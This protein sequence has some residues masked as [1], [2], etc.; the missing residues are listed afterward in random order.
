MHPVLLMLG[1]YFISAG[2]FAINQA[3]EW[4]RDKVMP[5]TFYRPLPQGK[6]Q[7]WQAYFLGFIFCLFGSF[8]LYVLSPLSAGLG[9]LTI[10]LY[11]GAYT[12]FWKRKMAFGAVPGAIPGAMPV[13]IGYAANSTNIFSL[14]C[15]YLF[16]IMFLWQMPHFWCLAIRFKD[17]YK[18]GGFPVLPVRVG[19]PRTLYFIGLYVFAYVAL[20]LASPL[21]VKTNFFYLLFVVPLGF[22]VLYEFIKYF[23]SEAQKG[24][25]PF[26]LWTNLSVLIFLGVPVFDKW[27]FYYIY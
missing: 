21:V 8:L 1:L 2:S 5:R 16:L 24:W 23:Q 7:P 17:D 27:L 14:E 18:K 11:N 22:K 26:F 19:V 4:R 3:Q 20:A 13:V 6:I 10:L 9:L 12:L 15:V 25:L